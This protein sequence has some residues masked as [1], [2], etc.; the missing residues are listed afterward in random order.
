LAAAAAEAKA[1]VENSQS[2]LSP[3]RDTTGAEIE[4]L[5][6]KQ[7]VQAANLR[8]QEFH[9]QRLKEAKVLEEPSQEL[10]QEAAQ[11]QAAQV[12]ITTEVGSTV[13]G[14]DTMI[15][16]YQQAEQ[17]ANAVA[18]ATASISQAAA[19]TQGPIIQN[20]FVNQAMGGRVGYLAN[21]GRGT[22]TI[23]AMLS[24]GETVTNARSSRRFFSQ[25]QAM[26][27]GQKP[28]YRNDGGD[29]YNTNV[30]DINVSGAASPEQTAR[31]VMAK[32]RREQRRGSAR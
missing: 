12:G 16:K 1:L 20:P 4:A 31:V 9:N 14:I 24:K 23:P 7:N 6:R 8:L 25:L 32:I 5:R 3:E 15:S 28:I 18:A 30:G 13:M 21:G 22:D 29:T 10:P 27:A 11:V 17:S 19:S 26:N 2:Q